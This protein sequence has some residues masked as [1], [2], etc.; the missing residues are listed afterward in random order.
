MPPEYL[1]VPKR[2]LADFAL[3][4]VTNCGKIE[5]SGVEALEKYVKAGGGVFFA[6]G[7]LTRGEY[8]TRDLYRNGEGLFPVPLAGPQPLAV[9]P[10]DNTPDVQS[11]EHPVFHNMEH[12][13]ENL[14]KIFVK[15]YF[16]VP[17]DWSVKR[18]P[19]VRVIMRLRNGAPLLVEKEFGHGRVLAFLSATAG[20][21]WN[22]WSEAET[23][24]FP[25][26]VLNMVPV[27]LVP[28][29]DE[30]R[31]T[32]RRHEDGQLRQAPAQGLASR[33]FH[34]RG[35]RLEGPHRD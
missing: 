5:R 4:C 24:S 8:V 7:A 16:A 2:P 26:F 15:Q 3:I 6:T 25:A 29:R 27:S 11:E 14:S 13:V 1:S 23:G 34:S 18:E 22:N 33:F 28:L 19:G 32:G 9:D 20:S 30:R 10:L 12:R 31:A 21:K 17:S 35:T